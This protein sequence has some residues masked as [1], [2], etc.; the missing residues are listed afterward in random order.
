[1]S[2]VK[3]NQA[4]GHLNM[5]TVY[6]LQGNKQIWLLNIDRIDVD[7]RSEWI[8]CYLINK[9]KRNEWILVSECYSICYLESACKFIGVEYIGEFGKSISTCGII[10]AGGHHIFNTNIFQSNKLLEN[11]NKKGLWFSVWQTCHNIFILLDCYRILKI[12]E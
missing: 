8:L 3:P 5:I 10:V 7:H 11:R 9:I 1:M 12:K 6:W 2:K 4:V